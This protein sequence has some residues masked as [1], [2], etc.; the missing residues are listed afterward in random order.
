MIIVITWLRWIET[1]SD[2][3]TLLCAPVAID[4][5]PFQSCEFHYCVV[6]P[7]VKAILSFKINFFD[8]IL[9]KERLNFCLEIKMWIFFIHHGSH[10]LFL[11]CYCLSLELLLSRIGERLVLFHLLNCAS[12]ITGFSHVF[13]IISRCN[14]CR[15]FRSNIETLFLAFSKVFHI[16]KFI[17]N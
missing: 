8:V 5:S 12:P 10:E 3:N 2:I 11:F 17:I 14:F 13:L 4:L 6:W 7:F 1:C 9:V 16:L 15:H